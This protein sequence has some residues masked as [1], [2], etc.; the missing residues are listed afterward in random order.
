MYQ[1]AAGYVEQIAQGAR[2][3]ELP[4]ERSSTVRMVVNLK[5]ARQQGIRIPQRVL[6]R[7]DRVIE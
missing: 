2:P 4:V 6:V 1:R 7:A 3:S 5:T